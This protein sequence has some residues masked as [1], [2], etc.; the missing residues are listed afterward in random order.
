MNLTRRHLSKRSHLVVA[1]AVTTA[2]LSAAEPGAPALVH[3]TESQRQSYLASAAI[4]SDRA[5]PSP[6]AIVRGP[7]DRSPLRN[8]T[9]NADGELT[10]R[11]LK[12]GAG[13][14]GRTEKFTCR[15]ADGRA[16]RV[17]YFDGNPKTGNREVFSEVVATRL[18]W[19]LGFDADALFPITVV[20][21]G[22][23]ENPN[24]GKGAA[25]TRKYAAVVEAL[26]E[27]TIVATDVDP[28]QG[29][30]FAEVDRAI[31]ALPDGPERRRQR[32]Q[33]DALA[34]L[35]VFVQHGDRK[36]SQQRLVCRGPLDLDAGDVHADDQDG[37][38]HLSVL[39]E[40]EG[41]R[42]CRETAITVQD[43]GATFGGAG[44]MTPRS[45][46]MNLPAWAGVPVFARSSAGQCRGALAMAASAGKDA[47]GNLV[48][49]EEGRQFLHARLSA[50]TPQH[51]RALFEAARLDA[52]GETPA[53]RDPQSGTTY[54]G[55]DAW[56]EVFRRKVA[57]IGAKTC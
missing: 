5:M 33:F 18:Y 25:A 12:G 50:L 55:I 35:S 8:V 32:T 41:A 47:G 6:E 22:C 31:T 49:S 56:V 42:A 24:S 20:C 53:W 30:G 38:F 26:Y 48:I 17:K 57:D 52:L 9:L 15:T 21:E 14:P 34:L 23:P 43:L 10:C 11:Y 19:A 39:F 1:L 4:W 3:T 36:P 2:A 37:A 27:G 45:S 51:V 46:K 44:L 16:V 54:S 28:D 40:R 13:A 7:V 29:W